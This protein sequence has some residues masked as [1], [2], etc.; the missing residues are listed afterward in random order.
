VPS[1]AARVAVRAAVAERQAK[2]GVKAVP[3]CGQPGGILHTYSLCG[4]PGE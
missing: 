1:P 3:E 4:I 2:A